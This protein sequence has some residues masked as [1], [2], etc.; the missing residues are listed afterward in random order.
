MLNSAR[1]EISKPRGFG[2]ID[3]FTASRFTV[4]RVDCSQQHRSRSIRSDHISGFLQL[5]TLKTIGWGLLAWLASRSLHKS[6]SH[7]HCW[8]AEADNCTVQ[9][10]DS[11]GLTT[12]QFLLRIWILISVS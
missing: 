5:A 11:V 2:L 3:Y 8:P 7:N 4:L 10:L 12:P 6:Q 9:R 1:Y